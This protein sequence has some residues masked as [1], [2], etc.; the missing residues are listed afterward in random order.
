MQSVTIMDPTFDLCASD[1]K[2]FAWL[3]IPKVTMVTKVAW[4]FPTQSLSSVETLVGLNAR[5]ILVLVANF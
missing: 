3:G 2:V 1:I 5:K 4:E